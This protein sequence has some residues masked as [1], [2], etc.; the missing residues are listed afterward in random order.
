MALKVTAVLTTLYLG[1]NSIR[2]EGAIAIAEALKVTAVL[3]TLDLEGNSTSGLRVPRQS[4]RRCSTPTTVY[5]L[6][7]SPINAHALRIAG[8]Q[9]T[10]LSTAAPST[11]PNLQ[12][13][14][15]ATHQH[16]AQGDSWDTPRGADDAGVSVRRPYIYMYV[17]A[18]PWGQ[19]MGR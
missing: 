4:R 18:G 13:L 15:P 3:T 16:A 8:S 7:S 14:R 6:L 11:D 5:T 19:C 1:A 10:R 12:L 9:L 2:D 17:P